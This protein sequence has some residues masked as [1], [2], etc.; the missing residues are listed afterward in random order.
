MI[1]SI[2]GVVADDG[3]VVQT[4]AGVGFE[5][6]C[7]RPLP[8]GERVWLRTSLS[9]SDRG[10]VLYGFADADER[11][12]FDALCRVQGVSGATALALLRDV[13]A[14]GVADAVRRGDPT[15]LTAARGVG[16]KAAQ[17]VCADV[18]RA[19]LPDADVTADGGD[20]DAGLVAALAGLGYA[21]ADA[22]DAL[23]GT[24]G[25]DDDRLAAALVALREART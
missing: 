13:G 3:V 19:A 24:R 7:P 11:D 21:E 9:V 4:A 6:R 15:P 23:A 25:G 5:V 17:R 10:A 1:G 14:G 8:P 22:R 16:R 18:D 12:V 2:E 20:V